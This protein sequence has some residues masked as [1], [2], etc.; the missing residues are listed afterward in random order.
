M[1][2]IIPGHASDDEVIQ[3]VIL[4]LLQNLGKPQIVSVQFLLISPPARQPC[5]GHLLDVLV[6]DHCAAICHCAAH[7]AWK[8]TSEEDAGSHSF[9]QKGARGQAGEVATLP[10]ALD[11]IEG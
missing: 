6:G 11:D 7:Q 4:T 3:E 10:L 5:V 1:Y 8:H 2:L 9:N